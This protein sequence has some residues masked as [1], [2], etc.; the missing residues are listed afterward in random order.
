MFNREKY[1][2]ERGSTCP[3][4]GSQ[5]IDAGKLEADG[6]YAWCITTCNTCHKSWEDIFTLTDVNELK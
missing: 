2:K 1:L 6:D 5:D 4:C 3:Y